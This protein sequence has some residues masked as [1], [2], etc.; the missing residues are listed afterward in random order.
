MHI[1][2]YL[3]SDLFRRKGRDGM[4]INIGWCHLLLLLLYSETLDIEICTK[5]I[6]N[7]TNQTGI[8]Q[9][10]KEKNHFDCNTLIDIVR[11]IK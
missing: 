7:A 3:I 1:R 2:L 8:L 5:L 9:S 6:D 10:C 4:Q 11:S